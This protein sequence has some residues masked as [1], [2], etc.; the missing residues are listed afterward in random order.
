[1]DGSMLLIK[2]KTKQKKNHPPNSLKWSVRLNRLGVSAT[3][4]QHLA[5][6]DLMVSERLNGDAVRIGNLTK[7]KQMTKLSFIPQ[8]QILEFI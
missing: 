7:N 3:S 1:M 8:K 4:H 6:S 5:S 2:N